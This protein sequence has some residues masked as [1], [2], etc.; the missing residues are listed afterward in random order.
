MSTLCKALVAAGLSLVSIQAVAQT[1]TVVN[2]YATRPDYQRYQTTGA[3]NGFTMPSVSLQRPPAYGTNQTYPTTMPQ[4]GTTPGAVPGAQNSQSS[5]IAPAAP[6]NPRSLDTGRVKSDST[7]DAASQAPATSVTATGRTA[8]VKYTAG[9][10][11]TG[12]AKVF[13][14]HSLLIG[15]DAVRLDG[16]D[17][18][19]A[20]QTCTSASGTAWRCGETAYRR[21]SELTADRKVICRVTEQVGEGAAAICSASGVTDIAAILVREGLAVPNGHD[22]GRYGGDS[23]AARAGKS[24]MWGGSF[25][26]PSKWRAAN[27]ATVRQTAVR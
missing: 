6:E 17:A 8:A 10:I 13:D 11:I 4:V 21:L 22:K 26:L 27:T 5:N 3:P 24:G 14:G 25:T 2:G 18:P 20:V 15:D 9:Q 23:N 19:G 7:K 12:K 1:T 16:A